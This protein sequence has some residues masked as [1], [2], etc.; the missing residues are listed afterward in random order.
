MSLLDGSIV[1]LGMTRQGRRLGQSGRILRRQALELA[2]EDAGVSRADIDGYILV[3][4]GFE[5]LRYLGLSP[6]FSYS[7][8]SGGASPGLAVL[9]AI[10]AIA[11]GQATYV[12]CVYGEAFTSSVSGVE[13]H[14]GRP[15]EPPDIGGGAYGYPYL[16]GQIGPIA[17]YAHAAQ[18]HMST[19]GTTSEHL[20]A[21]AVSEREYAC[22]RPGALEE[23]NPMTLA[24]HQ[25]SRIV[26]EPFR[27]LDC[28][29]ST[30]G[31]VAVIVTSQDRATD[32]RAPAVDVLGIGTGHN[33]RKWHE[34]TMYD[35]RDV[36]V[37]A[38]TAF[39]QA[40]ISVADID[41]A[42][43]YAPFSFAVI[44]QLED[45][46]FCAKGDGGAFV[47]AGH[48]KLS[49]TIPTNTGGGHLSGFYATG[50]TPLSEAI[51]QLRGAAPSSQVPNATIA[52]VSGTGG[53]G[54]ITG[55]SAHITLVLGASA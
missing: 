10:G 39:G 14:S 21:V 22:I 36:A 49:G 8:Q 46:G 44:D 45:Y 38:S 31:G 42:E 5:D 2:L 34:G 15:A 13:P 47:A 37:A 33:V 26:T 52:L 43:L 18:R 11:T 50:F 24:D 40:G 12:A 41:V 32:C 17:A 1:G 55:S 30:E 4:S 16:F 6:R 28:C 48:T 54:G 29:R 9:N 25:R 19:F 51:L 3:G 53:N 20:G 23:G 7:L 35:D 27:L